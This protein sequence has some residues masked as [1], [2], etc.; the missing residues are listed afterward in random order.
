MNIKLKFSVRNSTTNTVRYQEVGDDGGP[1]TEPKV[2]T[3][4]VRKSALPKGAPPKTL[5][6]TIENE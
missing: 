2:G 6:V 3:L 1:A 4:Y 5:S